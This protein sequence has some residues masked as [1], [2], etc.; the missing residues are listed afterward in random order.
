MSCEC[1]KRCNDSCL[2]VAN[3]LRCTDMCSCSNC[4]NSME[5]D[6]SDEEIDDQYESGDDYD[7]ED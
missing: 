1:K 6:M 7:E 3:D 2:C 5:I 4:G